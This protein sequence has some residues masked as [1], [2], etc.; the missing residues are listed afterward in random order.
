MG[1]STRVTSD[2]RARADA[3]ELPRHR[4]VDRIA[5]THEIFVRRDEYPQRRV[6][7]VEMNVGDK[8]IDRGID[9]ARF[10]AEHESLIGDEARQ[11]LQVRKSPLE[12][13]R[14]LVTPD[15]LVAVSFEIVGPGLLHAARGH[16][17]R[18]LE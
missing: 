7:L 11:R 16:A 14:G 15:A 10:C 1:M 18:G 9:A 3:R 8:S 12:Y 2:L 17:G 6:D 5:M 13:G 4:R